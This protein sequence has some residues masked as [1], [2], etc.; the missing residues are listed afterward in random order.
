MKYFGLLFK[1]SNIINYIS[2]TISLFTYFEYIKK[3]ISILFCI[4]LIVLV[5]YKFNIG[6]YYLFIIL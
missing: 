5:W 3:Q 6:K 2:K 1:D 4:N